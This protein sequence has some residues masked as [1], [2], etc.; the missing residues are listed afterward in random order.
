MI[1]VAPVLEGF[2]EDEIAISM[3]DNHYILIARAGLDRKASG[4][5]CVELADGVDANH[6][7][8]GRADFCC[9]CIWW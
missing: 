3:V 9:G 7:F 1:G 5:V 4:V 2:L 8:A 6:D